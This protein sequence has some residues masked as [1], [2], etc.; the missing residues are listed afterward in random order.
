MTSA[1]L[2]WIRS[3]S[4]SD[5][6]VRGTAYALIATLVLI[7]AL[8]LL[9]GLLRKL[10]KRYRARIEAQQTALRVQRWEM[11]SASAVQRSVRYLL[12]LFHLLA[13]VVLIDI[14]VTL[15]LRLFP[16]T[17]ALSGR[18]YE[19]VT[20]PVVVLYRAVVAY[21]PDLLHIGVIS[22]LALFS[23]R[24]MRLFFR[25]IESGAVR[26]PGFYTDWADPTYK[27]V[28]A[29]VLVFLL[30]AIFPHLPGADEQAFKAVS[31]FIGA[32][33]TL[34]ST[35][36]VGNAVAGV[37]LIYTRAFQVGDW[38]EVGDTK[39]EVVR[40]TLLVTRLRNAANEQVTI[41]NS[42]VLRDHVVNFSPAAKEGRLGLTVNVTIGY[43]V[44]WRTVEELLLKAA[45]ATSEISSDPP[46]TVLQTSF[47]D[48]GVSYLL[49]ACTGGPPPLGRIRT[50][51]GRNILDQFN[52]A[53]V[54]I[55]T[56]GFSVLRSGE[57]L[58]IP[59]AQDGAPGDGLA[60]EGEPEGRDILD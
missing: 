57:H 14:Y 38:I 55:L 45:R 19:L 17:E 50:A 12:G 43:D 1:F 21:I 46:P 3:L 11:V 47:D 34:G 36:A 9:A 40:R 53:G 41:P 60:G 56:P 20:A 16:A 31:L 27:L 49:W 33:L 30:I 58:A 15:V 24:F 44:D 37:V 23:L 5:A 51:L 28:R 39:G 13:A 59:G 6:D 32:L 2:D 26:L 48:F 52:R 10:Q 35:A 54:E 42:E 25:S 29:L 18:Y 22:A 4:W 7:V 8:G